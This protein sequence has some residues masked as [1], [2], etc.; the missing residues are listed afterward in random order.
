ML[1]RNCALQEEEF[2]VIL[3][4]QPSLISC[5]SFDL[6]LPIECDD[7]YWEPDNSEEAFKQPPEKPSYVSYFNWS[8]K[9]SNLMALAHRKSV[10]DYSLFFFLL[11][12]VSAS[13]LLT[14]SNQ[15]VTKNGT[16][17]QRK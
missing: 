15:E 17:A 1:G 2:V 13:V 10:S 16:N 7:E 4:Y 3:H 8:I 14:S 5:S 11:T 12:E 6:D 9:L